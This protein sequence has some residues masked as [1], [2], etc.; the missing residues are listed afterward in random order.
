MS[1]TDQYTM[2]DPR[3]QYSTGNTRKNESQ[4]KPGLDTKL[5]PKADHGEETYRGAARLKRRK[6]LITSGD[7]G[8]GRAV[9]LAFAREGADVVINYLESEGADGEQTLSLLNQAGVNAKAIE[10]DIRNESFCRAMVDYASTKGA[11]TT[12]TKGCAKMLIKRG[13]RING[14]APVPVWT[15]LQQSGEQPEEN[16]EE[17]GKHFPFGR[18]GQPAELAPVYVYL[19]SQESSYVTAEIMGVTGGEHLP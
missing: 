8:I 1:K 10:G 19:A 7:S 16:L 5:D 11:I 12:F 2:Q 14:V 18:P 17:F 15:P 9:A 4:P 6:A 3:H 13:I